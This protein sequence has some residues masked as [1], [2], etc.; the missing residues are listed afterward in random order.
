MLFACTRQDFLPR[1]R[2]TVEDLARRGQVDWRE[3]ARAALRHGVAP[4]VGANLR[5]CDPAALALPGEVAAVLQGALFENAAVKAGQAAHLERALARLREAG[6]QALL[7]KG[8]ALDRAVYDQ[9]SWTVSKDLDLSVR[10]VE[11]PHQDRPGPAALE[12]LRE[13]GA[14]GIECDLESHHDVTFNGLLPV[15]FR[16]IWAAARPLRVGREEALLPAPEDLLLAAAVNACRKRFRLKGLLDVAEI[17]WRL[18]G[19]DWARL[20]AAARAARAEG[21]VLAALSAARATIGVD[22]P[23]AHRALGGSARRRLLQGLA[24]GLARAGALGLAGAGETRG[25]LWGR[26]PEPAL[27]LAYAALHPGD[28]RRA[29]ALARRHPPPDPAELEAAARA[30]TPLVSE[31]TV[32]GANEGDTALFVEAAITSLVLRGER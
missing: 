23:R 30:G 15:D 27:L 6:L 13:L 25:G 9:P 22:L 7:L 16:S 5:R 8:A 29:L 14:E 24:A 11:N 31:L 28:A 10:P 19:L 4:L 26:R 3:L 21:L 18:P 32:H 2:A 20:A 17:V 1:H 12:V